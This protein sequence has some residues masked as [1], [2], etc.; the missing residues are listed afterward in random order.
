M[1]TYNLTPYKTAYVDGYSPDTVFPT[2]PSTAYDVTPY[3]TA[4][5]RYLLLG[6]NAWPASLKR[7][8]LVSMQLRVYVKKGYLNL[9]AYNMASNWDPATVTFNNKPSNSGSSIR[10]G[11]TPAADPNPPWDEFWM[12]QFDSTETEMSAQTNV[13]LN[14]GSFA[15]GA[16]TASTSSKWYI[17]TVLAGGGSPYLQ[18]TY[19]DTNITSKVQEVSYPTGTKSILNDISFTWKYVKNSSYSCQDETWTQ[20]S[21][22][23]Y[24]KT[25]TESTWHTINASGSTTSLTVPAGT[26]PEGATIQW[27][28]QG[29]DTDGTTTSTTQRSFTTSHSTITPS[30]YPSGNRVDN[31]YAIT[32]SWS[33]STGYSQRS[34]TLYWKTSIEQNWHSVEASG[35]TTS[36][37]IPAYTFPSGSTISWYISGIDNY[38]YASSSAQNSFSVPASSCVPSSFPS[39]SGVN[40]GLAISFL[41]EITS[42]LGNYTQ[43]SAVFH[44]K[45]ST[46]GTYTDIAI[47]DSTKRVTVPANTFPTGKTIQ[48]YVTAT[49]TSGAVSDSSAKNFNTAAPV[50]NPDV[51]PSGRGI[52]FGVDIPFSW[53]L[54]AASGDGDYQQASAIL[55][56][57]TNTADPWTQ[58]SVS[59]NTKSVTIPAYTFPSGK[60]VSWYISAVDFSG[61]SASSREATF[62]TATPQITPQDS[63]TSGY[64]DPRVAITFS[65]YFT[66]GENSYEQRSAALKWRIAGEENWNTVSASGTTQHVTVPA[67]T[68]P[69]LSTIEWMLTGIDRGGTGSETGIYSFSTTASTAY[70]ICQKPVGRVEDGTKPIV[71]TWLVRNSDGTE[72]TRIIVKWKLPTETASSWRTILD[73]AAA[74]YTTTVAADTF[75]SGPIDWEVIA[76]NKDS[77]AGPAGLASFVCVVA[78]DP[79]SGLTATAVPRTTI[80]WQ[81]SDQEAYEIQ[82]DG[83][84]V[85][86]EYGPTVTSYRQEEP[87]SNG[88]HRIRIRI[89]GPYGLWSNWAET[90]VSITNAP[91]GGI[92]LT[93]K[94]RVDGDLAWNYTGQADPEIVAIYRN[95]KWIGR[96]TGKSAFTDRFVLGEN[97][98][99]VEYWFAD[100][101]YTRSN[102]L[103][104]MMTS[105]VLRIAPFSGGEWMPLKLSEKSERKLVF[106]WGK[107]SALHSITG[108]KW[109]MLEVSPYENLSGAY[110]CAFTEAGCIKKFEQL[111]GRI[112]ILK[113]KGGEVLIGG[114]TEVVK[115]VGS[116]Y[117]TFSFSVQQCHWEDF[118]NDD[119]ND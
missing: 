84:T 102:D 111:R 113:N 69:I 4:R 17:R 51:Y 49:D 34:A 24:W 110:D 109:P 59:G 5:A 105:E 30:S 66:D 23:L 46:S 81:P 20:S 62:I 42:A 28:I 3:S 76:Y 12:T 55:Y 7:K 112:V 45:E 70:A 43:Q 18:V 35:S 50:L 99:R 72:P 107:T 10:L 37:T 103:T 97:T 95:G 118:V 54:Q 119:S 116:F 53:K 75:P 67:N 41:W 21:A 85:K 90:T 26:F 80:Q 33:F 58:V 108:S 115:T 57:R 16:M 93:G 79:P 29:T 22:K 48:W 65:W 38:G 106:S 2:N 15:V 94:L 104:G 114:L 14:K 44:W 74:V 56:W 47:T 1:P 32:F 63:P 73:E 39:G 77:I 13:V 11:G 9:F 25:S 88:V 52:N 68:F 60:T 117:T 27:Y 31:R 36:V 64:S 6:L 19:E 78:P 92:T 96:A 40:S 87:L 86:A 89:Q 98:Y 83:E 82:I 71:F 91:K 8:K 100:G 61:T 101:Y